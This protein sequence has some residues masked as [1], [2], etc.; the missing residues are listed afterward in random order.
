[1]SC[2]VHAVTAVTKQSPMHHCGVIA[3]G[4]RIVLGIVRLFHRQ[5]CTAAV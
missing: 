1:M 5:I 4:V 2:I 3:S